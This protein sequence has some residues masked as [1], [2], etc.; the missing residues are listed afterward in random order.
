MKFNEA[1]KRL[2][3]KP[4]NLAASNLCNFLGLLSLWLSHKI[5]GTAAPWM[6]AEKG[7]DCHA[8]L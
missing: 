5:E 4:H 6:C 2:L 8:D 7:I 1:E 3:V